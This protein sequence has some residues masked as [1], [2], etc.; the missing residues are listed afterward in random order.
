MNTA[1][2][3]QEVI[4]F[5][6]GEA[7]LDGTWFDQTRTGPPFWWREHLRKAMAELA[8]PSGEGVDS[9]PM[10]LVGQHNGRLHDLDYAATCLDESGYQFTAAAK[11][12]RVRDWIASQGPATPQSA[13]VDGV[14]SLLLRYGRHDADCATCHD[15]MDKPRP[16]CTCG[17]DA[18][19]TTPPPASQERGGDEILKYLDGLI[20]DAGKTQPFIG[21]AWVTDI[22]RVRQYIASTSAPAMPREF[23]ES[24]RPALKMAHTQARRDAD[25]CG[26]ELPAHYLPA[27]EA[28]EDRAF[29]LLEFVDKQLAASPPSSAAEYDAVAEYEKHRAGAAEQAKPD[30]YP[31]DFVDALR[32]DV[33]VRDSAQAQAGELPPLPEYE[34]MMTWGYTSDQM[35]DYANAC[36]LAGGVTVDDGR[37]LDWLCDNAL[38]L[39]L[40]SKVSRGRD[41][42]VIKPTREA[43]DAAIA[44]GPK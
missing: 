28:E 20:S 1:P 2:K 39:V 15:S 21:T 24:I 8:P 38:F 43:I 30:E 16:V 19:L 7:P 29:K 12:R 40:S 32:Y 34:G 41:P 14:R 23:L 4:A 18:A 33:A 5:L 11:V 36:R 6:M 13:P 27:M 26:S 35:R 17:L 3:L 22:E 25:R 10:H 44:A 9:P 37:R 42:E 31:P